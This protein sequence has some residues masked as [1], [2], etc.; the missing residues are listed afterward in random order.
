MA[1]TLTVNITPIL[2]KESRK[3]K[4]NKKKIHILA[5]F[6]KKLAKNVSFA[7]NDV[8]I[9]WMQPYRNMTSGPIE[10]RK[11]SSATTSTS[12]RKTSD[13]RPAALPVREKRL[14]GKHLVGKRKTGNHLAKKVFPRTHASFS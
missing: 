6:L 3:R 2:K 7:G 12:G 13:S 14:A 4:K 8:L 5:F 10:S 9:N 11:I 1:K